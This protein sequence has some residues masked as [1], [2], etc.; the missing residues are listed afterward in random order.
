MELK[1]CTNDIPIQEL[2][3]MLKLTVIIDDEV[4]KKL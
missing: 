3:K 1:D 4:R 2:N